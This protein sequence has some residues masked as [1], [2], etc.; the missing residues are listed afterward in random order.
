MFKKF[1]LFVLVLSLVP[2][3]GLAQVVNVG[4]SSEWEATG[5]NNG[6]RIVRDTNGYYHIVWHSQMNP[7]NPPMG[8]NCHIY[9]ACVSDTGVLWIAPS[10]MT[11]AMPELLDSRY[12][13]IAIEYDG[14]DNFGD[15]LNYNQVHIV[16]QGKMADTNTYEVFHHAIQISNP[17]AVPGPFSW[18]TTHNL[19]N[20]PQVDSLVPAI[21]INQFT[22]HPAMDQNVH[23]VWQEEDVTGRYGM[24][25]AGSDIFY[26]MSWDSGNN[27]TGPANL[28]NTRM[29]SQMPSI[30]CVLDSYYGTPPWYFGSDSAYL[31]DDVHVSYHE[32]TTAG[33]INVYY[34]QSP[35]NG[36]MWNAPVN[37]SPAPEVSEG[38]T[39]IAVD[40]E[41][42]YHV[43]LMDDLTRSEPMQGA[44]MPG[45]DP[46]NNQSFAGP[47]PGMYHAVANSVKYYGYAPALILQ[48]T[49]SFD[50]EFPTIALDREQ[51]L[52]LNWQDHFIGPAG[53]PPT[54]DVIRIQCMNTSP[55][56]RPLSVPVYPAWNSYA[57]IDSNDYYNDYL[58]PNLAHK[59]VSMYLN[60][61]TGGHNIFTEVWTRITGLDQP[62]AIA[63]MA[64]TIQ[65]LSD[66]L[67]DPAYF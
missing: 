52:D 17:P 2:L 49:P 66:A 28:T 35:N 44:Y 20:S 1:V 24:D 6:R 47:D 54:Y 23:V 36:A 26:S 29:N 31:S 62:N 38:Y 39:N 61:N 4:Q 32:N 41:D 64:K 56:T 60:V 3:S 45:I 5:F 67:R 40:M 58:F 57:S 34:L 16:W 8:M 12:P 59:K 48:A 25:A 50:R 7:N 15:W 51:N 18:A 33:G 42:R 10:C 55:V 63:A 9:Y 21:A 43:V 46:Y 27:W 11:I 53:V 37:L 30:S 19:S 13:S 14:V 65:E 22:S